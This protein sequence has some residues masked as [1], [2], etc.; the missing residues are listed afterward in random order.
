MAKPV[1]ARRLAKLRAARGLSQYR[2]AEL[3]G[4]SRGQISNYEQGSREPDHATLQKLA[5]F[6]DVSID[7]LLGRTDDPRLAT[8]IEDRVTAARRLQAIRVS[9]DWSQQDLA[10]R[11]GI[12]VPQL[13]RYESGLERL[14]DELVDRLAEVFEVDRR[15]FARE[16]AQAEIERLLGET[17]FR[18]P[19]KLSPEARKSVEDFIAFV[20]E[21]EERK[22][23]QE[24][25][26][27]QQ[28]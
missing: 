13:A 18:A 23:Q 3:L 7:Y 8:P 6:F 10:S 17:W 14:P 21:Q 28:Q 1:F 26:Q 22:K 20:I 9:R 16:I 27:G 19:A 15:Y 11:L 2:L 4:F 25:Q 24:K 12:T 5:D